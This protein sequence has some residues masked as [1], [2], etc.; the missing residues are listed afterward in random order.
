MNFGE[1]KTRVSSK[2]L[3]RTS[4]DDLDDAGDAINWLLMEHL[5]QRG[6]KPF[7]KET[8]LT[9]TASQEYVDLPSDFATLKIAQVEQTDGY[10]TMSDADWED[11]E[12]TDTGEPC[13][14][15]ILPA[16]TGWRMYLRYI[17]DDVYDIKIWYYAKQA[18]LTLD[19]DTP[20]L[21]VVYGDGIIISGAAWRLASE[22]GLDTDAGR[23]Y[24]IFDRIDLPMLL[25][26]QDI[27]QGYKSEKPTGNPYK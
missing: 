9:T 26:W 10:K 7:L 18:Q 3:G 6:L 17:P 12:M 4:A 8:V 14:K 19:A 21:S 1:L 15:K 11:F 20:I 16:A 24:N 25:K 5:P 13:K 2:V 22:K 27:L 23:W